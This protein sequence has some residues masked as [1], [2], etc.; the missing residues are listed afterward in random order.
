MRYIGGKSLLLNE[1][2]SVI[3]QTI[4]WEKIHSVIDIFAGSGV[5]SQFFKEKGKHLL[6]NDFLAFS[7]AMLRGTCG[8]ATEP[9]FKKLDVEPLKYLNNLDVSNV[10]LPDSRM[11]IYNNYSPHEHCE[12]MYFQKDNALKIDLI[13]IQIE[14]W[15]LQALISEEEYFYLLA[16]LL[17]AV[18]YVANTTG[19]YAAYLKFWD[20]RT[21]NSLELKAPVLL[22][23][24]AS[25]K[26]TNADYKTLLPENAD[27]LYADPPYNSREYLPNYHIMETIAK[28]D[29]PQIHGKT[30]MRNYDGQKSEFCKKRTV[31]EAFETMLRDTQSRYVII[32]YNNEGLLPTEDLSAICRKYAANDSFQLFEFPYRRYKNKIPN[33]KAGLMEQLYFLQRRE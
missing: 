32:S 19:V 21:Y 26:C 24:G 4:G 25:C 31:A 12:R 23:N 3:K 22:L 28:Y 33:N 17:A 10:S 20:I 13:R 1:I 18:P 8:M 27:L 6:A 14:Q 11:F 15:R 16:S 29:Y 7:Y 5:V 30:G 2:D 9:A